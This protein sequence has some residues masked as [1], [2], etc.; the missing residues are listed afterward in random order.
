MA[1]GIG[2]LSI[3]Y[4]FPL[5]C[6]SFCGITVRGRQLLFR[7]CRG[8]SAYPVGSEIPRTATSRPTRSPLTAAVKTK[9]GGGINPA[10]F[11]CWTRGTPPKRKN[12]QLWRDSAPFRSYCFGATFSSGR[13]VGAS[14][15]FSVYQERL[16]SCIFPIRFFSC[17]GRWATGLLRSCL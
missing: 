17:R 14:L 15:R 12:R 6:A 7:R 5:F 16:R 13:R 10:T 3:R 2:C 8:D 11:L 4:F 9:W 1:S